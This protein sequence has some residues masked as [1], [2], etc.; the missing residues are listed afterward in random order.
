MFESLW[1]L[2]WFSFLDPSSLPAEGSLHLPCSPPPF[3]TTFPGVSP[4]SGGVTGV[5]TVAAAASPEIKSRQHIALCL[6]EASAFLTF[7]VLFALEFL[8]LVL[9]DAVSYLCYQNARK[10]PSHLVNLVL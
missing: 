7:V 5:I 10:M 3:A 8:L 9:L 4:L 1:V 2:S 6:R